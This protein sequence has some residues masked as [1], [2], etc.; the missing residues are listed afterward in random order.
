MSDDSKVNILM[1]DDR[2][3]NLMALESTLG[4]IGLNLI[5]ANSGTEALRW[6]LK[7]EFAVILLDVMMPDMDGFETAELIR[8]RRNTEHT[9]IIFVTANTTEES[10]LIRGY[11]LG[12]VDYIQK[13]YNKQILRSKVNVFVDLYRKTEEIKKQADHLAKVNQEL[14][15]QISE[16]KNAEEKVGENEARFRAMFENAGIGI[17]MRNPE[18]YFIKANPAFESII[19][20]TQEELSQKHFSEVVVKEDAEIE[21]QL[22]EKLLKGEQEQFNFEKRYIRKDGQTIWARAVVTMVYNAKRQP[23]YAVGLSEDITAQRMYTEQLQRLTEELGQSNEELLKAKETAEQANRAKS[24]FLSTMS[25]EL[26]TPLNAILGFAQILKKDESIPERQRGFV[27]TMYRSGSHLLDMINDV[28]DISKIESGRME[29]LPED[30]NLHT[31]LNDIHNMFNMRAREKELGFSVSYNNQVP[32]FVHADIRRVRQVLINLLGNSVKFTSSGKISLKVAASSPQVV[33]SGQKLVNLS[34]IVQDTGRGIPEDQLRT[35]FE[36]FRQMK[37]TYSE[38]TGLGLAISRRIANIMGGDIK[39]E[40]KEGVGSIFRFDV[41]LDLPENEINQNE[42]KKAGISGIKGAASIKVLVVDDVSSNRIVVRSL[43]EPI[44]FTCAEAEDG[45]SGVTIAEQFQ[46]N[47]ILMDLRMPIMGG[48]EAVKLLRKNPKT[49]K[50][51][52]IAI[53]ASGYEAKRDE[54]LKT[55]FEGYVSKPFKEQELYDVL[56]KA[57]KFEYTYQETVVLNGSQTKENELSLDDLVP[58][59]RTLPQPYNEKLHDAIEVQDLDEI[60]RLVGEIKSN[61]L[62]K[63]NLD[64]LSK[65]AQNG[66]LRVLLKLSEA[67]QKEKADA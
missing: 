19:G 1:V 45:R 39:V 56:A 59:I 67:L 8:Q 28:L 36:P 44:G 37:G 7:E 35:I 55:G 33:E 46:P 32:E 43:L 47:I 23:I 11:S 65:S 14:E 9:P 10:N 62:T 61:K 22:F 20:Y 49:K 52:V 3:E 66:E 42:N 41:P 34:F 60:K 64:L 38:G 17:T 26:R 50:I 18:G 12:A 24:I 63:T 53:S 5:K 51:P 40:S 21:V 4:D 30:F 27:E 54:L 57:G 25:H 58:A 15:N 29:L 13:P 16:R 31:M 2:P 6:L 48:Q